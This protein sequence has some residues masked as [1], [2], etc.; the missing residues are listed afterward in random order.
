VT[1]IGGGFVGCEVAAS[2]RA[3]G[4][5][6]DLVEIL[7]AP[8]F[9]VLGAAGAA[10]VTALHRENGVRLHTGVGVAEVLGAERVEGVRLSDCT[11]ISTPEV[12]FGLGVT[13][14][15]DWL[16][17][18]GMHLDDGITCTAGGRTSVLDVFAL[19]DAARWRYPLNPDHRRLEHWTS[20]ADQARVVAANIIDGGSAELPD[21]PYF[22]SDQYDLRIQALGFIDP[23]DD[24]ELLEPEAGRK[25]LLYSHGG[26]LCAVVCFNASRWVMRMRSHI[27][28]QAPVDHARAAI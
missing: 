8:L 19:G 7:P 3:L 6:V 18:S 11:V 23:A 28:A 27:A 21:V 15:I 17:A 22:W 16:R 20:T 24:I 5:E 13:P 9:R 12:V 2:A 14:E 25:I 1:V 10:I 26:L 4:A